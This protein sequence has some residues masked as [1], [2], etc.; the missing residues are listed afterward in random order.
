[1][2]TMAKTKLDGRDGRKA[3]A[4]FSGKPITVFLPKA[5]EVTLKKTAKK[6]ARSIRAEV[7][8][9]IAK[10]YGFQLEAVS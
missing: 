5:L 1:M 8:H 2:G 10:A 7:R 3:F 9:L 4:G 6:N